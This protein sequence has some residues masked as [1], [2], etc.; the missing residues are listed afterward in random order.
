MLSDDKSLTIEQWLGM[1]PLSKQTAKQHSPN[2]AVV[3]ELLIEVR[4]SPKSKWPRRELEL[5]NR[6]KVSFIK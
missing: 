1:D 2:G 5:E 6:V 3:V 4:S